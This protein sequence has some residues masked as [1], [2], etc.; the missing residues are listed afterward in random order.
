VRAAADGVHP[1]PVH[2]WKNTSVPE[3]KAHDCRG[4]TGLLGDKR[5]NPIALVGSRE[6]SVCPE[7][8]SLN[9]VAL[10]AD[11]AFIKSLKRRF[12]QFNC[13]SIH[14]AR[15]IFAEQGMETIWVDRAV[16]REVRECTRDNT[17]HSADATIVEHQAD[18]AIG[19]LSNTRLN[20]S[21]A[22]HL[23]LPVR[24]IRAS[25]RDTALTPRVDGR[26]EPGGTPFG[27]QR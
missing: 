3:Q 12:Q 22:G 13:S 8:L 19:K 17:V 21:M 10:T 26:V 16:F 4:N 5:N 15:G 9:S 6:K 27:N 20:K 1:A 14:S 11:P 7:D 25:G 24:P 18:E 23:L 2:H